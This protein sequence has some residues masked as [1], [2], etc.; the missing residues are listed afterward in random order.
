M[1]RTILVGILLVSL[2]VMP[3]MAQNFNSS[4]SQFISFQFGVPIGIGLDGSGNIY[5]GTNF[6]VDFAIIDN[7]AVGF[8]RL[9]PVNLF[10]ISYSFTEQ[11]GF[12]LGIGTVAAADFGLTANEPAASIGAYVNFF[13]TRSSIG[14]AY[15]MSMRIDYI[16]ETGS[17]DDGVVA[18]TLGFNL[19]L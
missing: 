15:G 7:L 13:Q 19:G 8:N 3:V 18:L 16:A 17:I 11:F 6:G 9:G 12:G 10:R 4:N 2:A 1:K 5:S 14:F